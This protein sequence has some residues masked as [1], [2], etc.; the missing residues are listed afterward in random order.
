MSTVV[1]IGVCVKNSE[2]TIKESMTSIV[3]QDFPHELMEVII[4]DG[5]S[6]DKTLLII[7]ETLSETGIETRFFSENKGLGFAR[8][9]V[10]DNS[11]G[12]YIVW[13]DGDVI[14]SENY[15]KQQIQFM[16][17]TPEAAIA[18]G[19]MGL[20]P[21][22]NWVAMLESIGYVI[23][24]LNNYGG[25]TSKLLGTRG[26]IFRVEAIKR[27]GGFDFKYKS[28]EDTDVAYKLKFSGWKFFATKAV[29][30]E[31]QK[32]KWKDIWKRH[33]WYGYGLHFLQ[34]KH[35]GFNIFTSK[36]NDRI[37]ISSKAYKLT[38]KKVAFL[39]PL[40]FI[41]RKIAEIFGFLRA[42]FDGYGHNIR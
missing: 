23:E 41:I 42:H 1:T 2:A 33:L 19:K 26:S 12:K 28:H 11:R 5:S 30:Y 31:K 37:V 20:I 13:V 16:E 35:K 22:D 7:K 27:I 14:L 36:T 39:L 8:Q 40:N 18:A 6:Q 15:I 29:L 34:H 9:M 25:R 3:N 21:N 10:V 32:K 17:K 4:V 24:S 38:H